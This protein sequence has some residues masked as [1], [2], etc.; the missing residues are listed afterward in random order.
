MTY[1]LVPPD[2]QRRNLAEKLIQTWKDHIIVVMS[3]T[4][5]SFPDHLRCQAIQQ[6]ERQLLI[7]QQSNVN[8]KI[9]AYA[10]I[11]GPHG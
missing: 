8:P 9:S 1:Q 3:S 11:Y 4:E 10:Y 5:E 2:D 6:A 7:L